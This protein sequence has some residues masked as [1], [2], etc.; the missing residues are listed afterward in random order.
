MTSEGQYAE[1]RGIGLRQEGGQW[2]PGR[3]LDVATET[4]VP[5]SVAGRGTCR[6]MR[7]GRKESSAMQGSSQKG[8]RSHFTSLSQCLPLV[9]GSSCSHAGTAER[10][11]ARSLSRRTLQGNLGATMKKPCILS[12]GGE[13]RQ[14]LKATRWHCSAFR[15]SLREQDSN[16][17][18]SLPK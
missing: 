2:G 5:G 4:S 12:L 3:M 6:R 9:P 16:P 11:T 13:L 1:T 14:L 17:S 8:G 15:R 7:K 10:H 18:T